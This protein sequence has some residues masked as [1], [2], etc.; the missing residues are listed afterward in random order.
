MRQALGATQLKIMESQL[1]GQDLE[2]MKANYMFAAQDAQYDVNSLWQLQQ[3]YMNSI[4]GPFEDNPGMA[5]TMAL[6]TAQTMAGVLHPGTEGILGDLIGA[7]GGGGGIFGGG[8]GGGG[9]DDKWANAMAGAQAGSVAGPWG[10]AIG[11]GIGYF[12]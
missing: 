7:G 11:A 1:E 5:W 8:G 9:G 2:N 4:K 10:T 12:S 3:W 6:G